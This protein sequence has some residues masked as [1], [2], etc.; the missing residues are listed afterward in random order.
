MFHLKEGATKWMMPSLGVL[1][2]AMLSGS[3]A[4]QSGNPPAN[5][6]KMDKM[7]IK[8]ATYAGC[9]E[10]GGAPGTFTLTHLAA[11]DQMGKNAMNKD[12]VTKDSMSKN[13]MAPSTWARISSVGRSEQASGPEGDRYRIACTGQDGQDGEGRDRQGRSRVYRDIAED[14]RGIVP[15]DGTRRPSGDVQCRRE[16][17]YGEGGAVGSTRGQTGERG[18][19]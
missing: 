19:R 2:A 1:V 14:R 4:A 12:T 18:R 17:S 10:A 15:V 3:V 7:A 9:V 8:D 16:I 13:A 11:D 5:G 6:G